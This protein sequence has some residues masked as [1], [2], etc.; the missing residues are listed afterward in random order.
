MDDRDTLLTLILDYIS[1][2]SPQA[3]QT[4][5]CYWLMKDENDIAD[6]TYANLME[7]F[8][9][10]T[11]TIAGVNDQLKVAGLIEVIEKEDFGKFDELYESTRRQLIKV[12]PIRPFSPETR[13]EG[14]KKAG[15]PV[16]SSIRERALTLQRL[17]LEY[18]SLLSKKDLQVALDRLGREKFTIS[19]LIEF[20]KLD[21]EK[22]KLWL[23]SKSFKTQLVKLMKEVA[24]EDSNRAEMEEEL[25]Q[26]TEKK[27]GKPKSYNE[28][29]NDIQKTGYDKDGNEVPVANWKAAQ[30]LRHFCILYEKCNGRKYTI[31]F[32]K[33]NSIGCRELK[34]LACV[35]HAFDENAAETV[36]YLDW[37]FKEKNRV[38]KDGILNTAIVKAA[39]MINEYKK[40]A[41]RPMQYMDTDPIEKDF[42]TWIRENVSAIFKQYDLD[43]MKDLYWLKEAYDRGECTADVYKVVDEGIKRKII[44]EK[45][46]LAFKRG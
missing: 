34:E 21:K 40:K 15:L 8:G 3:I 41:S 10:A 20:F 39:G 31:M 5:M 42:I 44:P 17:P 13:R 36:R 2:L 19:N 6:V 35:L 45:G 18:Q 14:F 1:V 9:T 28:L 11:S 33:N 7:H 25:S 30:L 43:C 4:Y 24:E 12:L 29:Y 46:N 26:I 22:V 16:D 37:I 23:S 32:S 27:R 38:L